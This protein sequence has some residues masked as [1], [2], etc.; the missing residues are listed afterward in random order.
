LKRS[1]MIKQLF[2]PLIVPRRSLKSINFVRTLLCSQVRGEATTTAMFHA[3]EDNISW[4]SRQTFT[5]SK[6]V[7]STITDTLRHDK[8]RI[9]VLGVGGG[10][11]NSVDNMIQ[12]KLDGVEFYVCNTDAQALSRSA[13]QN[14][15]QIGAETTGGLGSG[16]QPHIGRKSAEESIDYVF[17][18]LGDTNLLFICAG[19]GGG[20]GTGAAPVIGAAAKRRGILT[21][22]VITTPFNF[23][24]SQRMT[25]A[26][27]GLRE[28]ERSVDTMIIVPNENIFNVAG[29]ETPLVDAFK[30]NDQIVLEGIRGITDIAVKP[31]LINLDFADI[32]T[33]V[34]RG[35]RAFM[36]T[37]FGFTDFGEFENSAESRS[38]N[39]SLHPFWINQQ[40]SV[41][42]QISVNGSGQVSR[43]QA[44]V[45]AALHNPLLEAYNISRS[46]NVLLSITGSKDTTLKEIKD[47]ANIVKKNVGPDTNMIIGATFV[48]SK[49]EYFF[50]DG[51]KVSLVITGIP[52]TEIKSIVDFVHETAN[53]S[54]SPIHTQK[55]TTSSTP[56][57]QTVQQVPIQQKSTSES[58]LIKFFK[59]HW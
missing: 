8:V 37:G 20:T 57:Q 55:S 41:K 42:N 18:R 40:K 31:G 16:A 23:E 43:G 7:S 34:Q 5:L 12:A 38:Q 2:K 56:V 4:N 50:K 10:G 33:V 6:P 19:L 15:I 54:T 48:D 29:P 45:L 9:V 44:A 3:A 21:V 17:D 25:T 35:G 27:E 47:I 46:E 11:C 59:K 32:K 30:L 52:R 39:N 13:C 53:A 22:G 51:I 14:R 36:G 26:I 1:N 28:L 49:E 58:G 24:G